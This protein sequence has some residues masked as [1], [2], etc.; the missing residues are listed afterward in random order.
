MQPL[1]LLLPDFAFVAMAT[2]DIGAVAVGAESLD[3]DRARFFFKREVIEK[4][5]GRA[6]AAK[7]TGGS[8]TSGERCMCSC[9]EEIRILACVDPVSLSDDK[10]AAAAAGSACERMGGALVCNRRVNV[11]VRGVDDCCC[12]VDAARIFVNCISTSRSTSESTCISFAV[13]EL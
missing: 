1:L 6:L 2:A 12:D 4:R 5:R 11:E 9:R 7:V 13:C 10:P 8:R 3:L